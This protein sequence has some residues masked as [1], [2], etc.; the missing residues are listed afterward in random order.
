MHVCI[1]AV[2]ALTAERSPLRDRR[3]TALPACTCPSDEVPGEKACVQREIVTI[4]PARVKIVNPHARRD[5]KI[6]FAQPS[7]V[8][9]PLLG[10]ARLRPY[11]HQIIIITHICIHHTTMDMCCTRQRSLPARELRRRQ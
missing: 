6:L 4:G 9:D 10:A 7:T 11:N 2:E 1:C 8:P 5:R 3:L